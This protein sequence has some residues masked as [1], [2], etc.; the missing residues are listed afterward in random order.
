MSW[1]DRK[2][3]PSNGG[4]VWRVKEPGKGRLNDDTSLLVGASKGDNITRR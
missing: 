4:G 1:E 2:W 3:C